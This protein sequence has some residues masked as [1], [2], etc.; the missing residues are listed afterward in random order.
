VASP[1]SAGGNSNPSETGAPS[2]PS[3]PLPKAEA[4]VSTGFYFLLASGIAAGLERQQQKNKKKRS[5]RIKRK[6]FFFSTLT[7]Q[8]EKR[9][10]FYEYV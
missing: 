6:S 9:T 3:R 7:M 4:T 8:I 5:K 10:T 1:I 2:A